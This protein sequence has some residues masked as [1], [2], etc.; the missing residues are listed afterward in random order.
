MKKHYYLNPL[1]LAFT[2][3]VFVSFI[4]HLLSQKYN[5]NIDGWDKIV[6]ATTIATFWFTGASL[7]RTMINAQE[8]MM[9]R[10]ESDKKRFNEISYLQE[11]TATIL[12]YHAETEY[13]KVVSI[14]DKYIS[15][16]NK[17]I[18]KAKRYI[19]VERAMDFVLISC[20]FL[21]FFLVIAYES[22]NSRIIANQDI[23]TMATFL[24]FLVSELLSESLTN[25]MVQ[26]EEKHNLEFDQLLEDQKKTLDRAI[27]IVSYNQEEENGQDEDAE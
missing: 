4:V 2:V 9:K 10:I 11:K 25:T 17:R 23:L 15:Q 8:Q 13:E 1:M 18:N 6:A 3:F 26:T 20:G 7:S 21:S 12:G 19:K 24:S 16:F 14:R 22:F 27:N 5:W